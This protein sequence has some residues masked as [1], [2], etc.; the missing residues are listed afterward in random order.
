MYVGLS[1]GRND[2]VDLAKTSISTVT[3]MIGVQKWT[4]AP[5]PADKNN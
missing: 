5:A 1:N 2:T 3:I 4:L